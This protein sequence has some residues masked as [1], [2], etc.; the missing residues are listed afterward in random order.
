[1]YFLILLLILQRSLL[2]IF[3]LIAYAF[4]MPSH[5]IETYSKMNLSTN[6]DGDQ[7][8]FFRVYDRGDG[9]LT[10]LSETLRY[11]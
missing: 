1:M 4:I 8:N 3:L 10:P 11:T 7:L 6:R 2:L 5:F 9:T